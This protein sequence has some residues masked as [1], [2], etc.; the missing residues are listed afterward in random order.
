MLA[1]IAGDNNDPRSKALL[2]EL[3]TPL[4]TPHGEQIT[5]RPVRRGRGRNKNRTFMWQQQQQ[6]ATPPPHPRSPSLMGSPTNGNVPDTTT[7]GE[8]SSPGSVISDSNGQLSMDETG[9]VRYLGKSSGFYLLQN[10]RTYQNGAFHLAGWGHR[11]K[12]PSSSTTPLDP[13]ELPPKDLSTH[14]IHLYFKHFY[15]ILPIFYKRRLAS[16]MDPPA[17]A[18]SPLLLNAIYAVASRV[19]P[20]LRVRSDPGSAD[21]A[22]DIYFERAKCLLDSYYDVP[23][24]STVQALLLMALHQHGSM[25]GPRAWLYSGLVW[26]LLSNHV[27]SYIY[28]FMVILRRFGWPKILVLTGIVIIGT[29]SQ[30]NVSEENECFGAVSLWIGCSV[31]TLDVHQYSKNVI[32]MCLFLLWMMMSH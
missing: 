14:L 32:V 26:L 21:T 18:I 20:D 22:G 7:V 15:P 4:E 29:S 12:H 2:A 8:P 23:R 11:Y 30:M 25:R 16:S 27:A 3:H 10:S 9:Q 28:T 6:S 31:P 13:L 17:D 5:T 1:D 19:S 24:I